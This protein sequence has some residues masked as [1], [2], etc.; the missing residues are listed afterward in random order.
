MVNISHFNGLLFSHKS[1]KYEKVFSTVPALVM[2]NKRTL[3][4]HVCKCVDGQTVIFWK[5]NT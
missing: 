2:L 5:I 4:C 1:G 3:L